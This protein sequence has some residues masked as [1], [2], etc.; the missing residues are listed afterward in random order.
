VDE[1]YSIEIVPE[2]GREA[3]RTLRRLDYENVHTRVGD[4]F[5]GWPEHAPFDKI[6]VT[7]SPENVPR[8][9][10]EQLRDGG[11]MVIPVGQRYQQTLYVL[12]KEEGHLKREPLRPT[13]FVPMTGQ[14]EERRR[15]RPDPTR[16]EIVN[17]GFE[18]ALGEE[19]GS[20]SGPLPE[21][22]GTNARPLAA[23]WH[24]QRQAELIAD[25]DA[26]EGRRYIRFHNADPGRGCRALQAFAVDGREVRAIDVALA[27]RGDDLR[28]GQ[29][30]LQ[31]AA[32]I[33]TF[34]D[35]RRAMVGHGIVGPWRASFDWQPE[36][37]RLA[38]PSSAREAIIR[39]GLHGGLGTLE[40]DGLSIAAAR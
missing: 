22:Q 18:Q 1:V 28:P 26:P 24:Y 32:L 36:R 39:I 7:C 29:D 20:H 38:V 12:R 17:G 19:P 8:P 23:G 30:R 16:P 15:V 2:L 3:A 34:Y 37:K 10:V 35:E 11:R 21:E 6:I 25:E 31:Q 9:L 14:A 33:V 5:K 13:L 27:V 4:G 40:I